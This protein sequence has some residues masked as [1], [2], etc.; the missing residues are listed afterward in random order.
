VDGAAVNAMMRFLRKIPDRLGKLAAKGKPPEAA[1]ALA[2]ALLE[3]FRI[4]HSRREQALL[5]LQAG[6]ARLYVRKY[7]PER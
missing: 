4:P 3:G 2:G 1:A 5:R 7:P 6:L